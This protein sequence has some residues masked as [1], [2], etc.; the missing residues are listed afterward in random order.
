MRWS[1]GIQHQGHSI[2]NSIL[3]PIPGIQMR[4]HGRIQILR[5]KRMIACPACATWTVM[6]MPR[7]PERSLHYGVKHQKQIED[8]MHLRECRTSR[9]RNPPKS[10]S[11]R[12]TAAR[13]APKVYWQVE[14]TEQVYAGSPSGQLLQNQKSNGPGV[15]DLWDELCGCF[16]QKHGRKESCLN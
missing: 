1:S 16:C 12:G 2:L 3:A 6:E 5:A 14:L 7:S 10:L 13:W 11:A 15:Y 8:Y 4:K 9:S